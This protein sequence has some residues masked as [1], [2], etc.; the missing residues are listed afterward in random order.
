M[1]TITLDLEDKTAELEER[2]RASSP[3]SAAYFEQGREPMAG[4]AKGAYYY[5]PYPL[6]MARGEGCHL[7]D[8]EG[9]RY[10]DCANHHTTLILGHNHPAVV[11]AISD[12]LARGPALGAPAGVEA[13]TC[14]ELCSRVATLDRVRYCNSGT[15]AT[16]HAI[17]LARGFTGRPKIAKFEGGYH[18]SHDAVEVSVSPPLD[19]AGS[20][21]APNSVPSAGGMSP[22]AG[23]DVVVLPY[24]N[25]NSVERILT[26][27]REELACVIF[28][29]KAGILPQRPE[30]VRFMREVT[31]KLDL[32]LIFDEIVGFRLGRGGLQ[33]YY[34]IDPDLTTYG[35]VVG[36]GLPA[37]A[38]GG[39]GDIMDLFD[40]TKDP[41]GFFQS[42]SFS[43]S[44]LVMVAGLATLQQLTPEA[45][46]HLNALGDRLREGLDRVFAASGVGAHAVVLGSLFSIYFTDETPWTQREMAAA[47]NAWIHPLFL[48]L[49][50]QGYFLGHNLSMCCLSAAMENEHVDGLVEAVGNVLAFI[51]QE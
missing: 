37:G 21:D 44:P 35:K 26:Q 38:F 7:E 9:R 50:E 41:P 5:P 14:A 10:V 24:N 20:A 18:G 36:G 3:K 43:A 33:E 2:Y 17:R 30:F 13:E 46:A 47:N 51:E 25:E 29:P 39:R 31:S 8:I 19:K 22:Y 23:Q 27:H 15:E 12:Q 4:P 6:V 48:S 42:G 16:L 34:G 45:F 49:L 28:D 32:L 11:Q 1:T 40:P